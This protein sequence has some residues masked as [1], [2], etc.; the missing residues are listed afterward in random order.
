MSEV[1]DSEL[2][3]SWC[4][5]DR[6][7]YAV[8]VSRHYGL[9]EAACRRQ[10]PSGEAE[11]CAQ[12]VFLILARKPSAAARAPALQAWL[13]RV[14]WFVCEHA[15]RAAGRR[16][17][18][19]RNVTVTSEPAETSEALVH[20]DGC[21]LKLPEQQR[22]AVTL[23]YLAG[24]TPDEV[25]T[26][27][28]ITRNHTYQ[29]LSRGLAGLRVLLAR[30]GVAMA[31]AGLIGVLSAE[32]HAAGNSPPTAM[33]S[34]L[35]GTPSAHANAHA[36]G[37]MTS[38]KIAAFTAFAPFAAAAGL[39]L[40][41]GVL[42]LALTAESVPPV[43]PAAVEEKPASDKPATTTPAEWL[44]AQRKPAF[45]AG[46]TLPRLTRYGWE[47]MPL[48]TG[49]PLAEDW[50]YALEF[51]RYVTTLEAV[52]QIDVPGSREAQT[53]A[54][55]LAKPDIY[56][57]NV[58]TTQA[59]PSENAPPSAYTRDAA[60]NILSGQGVSAD[61][62]T[63][64]GAGP[65]I[66]LEAPDSFWA[67]A[68]ELR[69]APLRALVA[70]GIPIDSI[71][72][73]GESGL[74]IPGFADAVW[75]KDPAIGA[76]IGASI[77]G[78]GNMYDHASAKKG[79]SEL[80]MAAITK[81]AVPGR[82]FF[83]YYA[84]GGGTHRNQDWAVD[85]WGPRWQHTRGTNDFPSNE[86]Y[87]PSAGFTTR[88]NA[89]T[90]AINAASLEIAT[91]DTLS[92][93]WL[94]G[95]WDDNVA[96]IG[97]WTGFLKCY[98]TV[99]MIGGN[100]GKYGNFTQ[101][102]YEAPFAQ[103]KP[104]VWLTQLVATSYAHAL[105]SQLEDVLRNGDLLPGPARHAV[106][107]DEP[108][109]EF[110]TGDDTARVVVRKHRTQPLW[111]I[112]A[113][114]AD[115]AD[116]KVPIYVP[117]L[118]Q[119]TVEARIVGSVYKATLDK[120]KVTLIRQDDEGATYSAVAAGTPVVTPVNLTVPMPANDRLLWLVADSGVT[121]DAAGKVS[122]WASQGPDGKS[123]VKVVQSDVARRP[124]LVAK[125]VNG[126]PAIRF[127]NSFLANLDLGAQG[128]AFIGPLTVYAVFTDANSA[129]RGTVVMAMVANGNPWAAEQGFA[130]ANNIA[131]NTQVTQGVLLKTAPGP[132]VAK[133]LQKLMI[134]END[135]PGSGF[136]F[137]GDL[138]E[139]L[140]Y[141]GQ[142]QLS[143]ERVRL[144]LENKYGI[145]RHTTLVNGDFEKPVAKNGFQYAPCPGTTHSRGAQGWFF[146][147]LAGIQ[148]NGS[149]WT[150][151]TAPSGNQTAVV[152]GSAGRLGSISQM[153]HLAA[154]TY[155]MSLK[156]ARGKDQIQPL[157]FT[158]DQIQIGG[159]L[160]PAGAT[161]QPL[162]T[163]RFI[164]TEGLHLL[165][166]EATDGSGDKSTLLD[167]MILQPVNAAKSP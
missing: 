45:R 102:E 80:I 76:A 163:G 129:S 113:W 33:L 165:R 155:T 32:A 23:H 12:A 74:G 159:L 128:D 17:Q 94:S 47:C 67:A 121:A 77:W 29:L 150:D 82:T 136:G 39:L 87:F 97:R 83:N 15:R 1:P 54:L 123:G 145:S 28:G 108:A 6:D 125:A 95:G 2:L 10:A 99:G 160:T 58:A 72:N 85:A 118:G 21:L 96:D 100:T 27:L 18:A 78:Q 7:A 105:F 68:G 143:Q 152:Q 126:K 116:R 86:I 110:P 4:A 60:G 115:G 65:L 88:L 120:G 157:K 109:Y 139:L 24:R 104:P 154:G 114:A 13:L 140:V 106:S 130:I 34:S 141:K 133:R 69:A 92:Y 117:E 9:V 30:R 64:G 70:R 11:D 156:A 135:Q 144:Y 38:M 91:G 158:V 26:T 147:S 19:E 119:L 43:K 148:A 37:A 49:K 50:G 89:L 46:H 90:K 151:A 59:I 8:L 63:W 137:T 111:L 93:N 146:A 132:S 149:G 81:A 48:A 124:T 167:E 101:G 166:F 36:Y 41:G 40:M 16:K 55:A 164:V 56:K 98:Y 138:A 75:N 61:G 42:T 31:Q 79:N 73:G 112:T 52:A 44:A 142:S 161:F 134:G 162:T 53:V 84:A 25:A 103:G 127:A 71:L 153:V 122:A 66:S 57:L 20:L 22:E 14:A 62:T 3:T 107:G 51:T 131:E 35:S 5:G